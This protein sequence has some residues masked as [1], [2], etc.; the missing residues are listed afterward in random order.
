MMAPSISEATM[1][2]KFERMGYSTKLYDCPK[3]HY[4]EDHAHEEDKID[5]ILCGELEVGIFGEKVILKAGDYIEIPQNT[6]HSARVIGD[7]K[8]VIVVCSK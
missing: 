5:A 1:V 8:F 2:K 7:E 4:L 6:V 3:G